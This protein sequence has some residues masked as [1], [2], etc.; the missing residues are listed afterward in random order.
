M[1][2][3]INF[4][5]DNSYFLK[6]SKTLYGQVLKVVTELVNMSDHVWHRRRVIFIFG[7]AGRLSIRLVAQQKSITLYHIIIQTD[8]VF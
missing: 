3:P 4:S 7:S 1:N 5:Q 6:R 8:E 2:I